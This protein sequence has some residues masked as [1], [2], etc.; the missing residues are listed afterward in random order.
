MPEQRNK[1]IAKLTVCLSVWNLCQPHNVVK[2]IWQEVVQ[3]I[4][5]Y[6]GDYLKIEFMCYF[7]NVSYGTFI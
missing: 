7:Y 2:I 1:K 4:M 5:N 6:Q 3:K